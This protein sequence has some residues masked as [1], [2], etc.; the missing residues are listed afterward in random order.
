M[1]NKLQDYNIHETPNESL[2]HP[3]LFAT[4]QKISTCTRGLQS[5]A[6]EEKTANPTTNIEVFSREYSAI[7]SIEENGVF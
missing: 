7:L 3:N 2:A 1:R 4:C 6:T 5:D